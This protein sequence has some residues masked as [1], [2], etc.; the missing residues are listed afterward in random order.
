MDQQLLSILRCPVTGSVLCQ[1]EASLIELINQRIEQG[2]LQTRM[3]EQL[4]VPIDAGLINQDQSLLMPIYLGIP[5]MNPDDAI[6]L[7]D[8]DL[9]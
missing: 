3:M 7:T 8:L 6:S 9:P 1:A 4:E 5:D 2:N